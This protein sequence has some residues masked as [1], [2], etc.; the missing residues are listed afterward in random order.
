MKP[1]LNTY[2]VVHLNKRTANH[3]GGNLFP[4]SC[5]RWFG[6]APVY[7]IGSGSCSGARTLTDA[8]AEG[9]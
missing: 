7:A 8:T 1:A 9:F 5:P 4:V 2:D 3:A 6:K